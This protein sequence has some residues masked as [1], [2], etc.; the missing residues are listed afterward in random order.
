MT[1]SRLT[2]LSR[3]GLSWLLAVWFTH[4]YLTM[5]WPKF[6]SD[7]FWTALFEHW[8]YPPSLRILVG[9][10]EVAAGVLL[11]L[12]TTTTYAA[13]ALIGVMLGAAGSLARDARWNDV[14]TV[15]YYL[16]GLAWI[17]WEWRAMRWTSSRPH[18]V[19]TKD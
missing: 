7:S 12:P 5:G 19:L 1:L 17:A 10:V 9:V 6:R 8:G 15:G 16:V 13:L 2:R 11:L 3:L 14:L 18:A 4:L